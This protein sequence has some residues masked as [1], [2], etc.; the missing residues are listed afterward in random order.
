MLDE[1]RVA[2]GEVVW[3]GK[4]RVVLIRP[5][6]GMFAMSTLSFDA[7]ITKPMAF[8]DEV[9]KVEIA[10]AE[11]SL[12]KTLIAGQTPATFDFSRYKDTYFQK[13]SELIEAKI[14]GKEIVAAQT[15]G[16]TQIIDLMEALQKS[17]AKMSEAKPKLK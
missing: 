2:V 12:A 5:V 11:M 15:H 16:E 1:N 17:V 6:D 13:V 10:P 7:E 8:A 14:A 9:P 3:H 4:E